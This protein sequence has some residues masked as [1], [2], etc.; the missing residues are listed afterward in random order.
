MNCLQFRSGM[1]TFYRMGNEDKLIVKQEPC[2]RSPF[3]ERAKFYNVKKQQNETVTDYYNKL[4]KLSISCEFSEHFDYRILCDKFI[5][6]FNAGFIF[7][8]LCN[9]DK[10]I[11]LHEALNLALKCESDLQNSTIIELNGTTNSTTDKYNESEE[12]VS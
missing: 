9:Q 7:E 8:H 1:E 4:L 10:D 6:G 12:E 2:I 3:R 11:T 5:T